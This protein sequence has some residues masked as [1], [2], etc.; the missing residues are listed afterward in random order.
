MASMPWR[1]AG[2]HATTQA[3]VVCPPS[4]W[5]R[6]R[7]ARKTAGGVARIVRVVLTCRRAVA[8]ESDAP[9][10][11]LS[12][13]KRT[14]R[15]CPGIKVSSRPRVAIGLGPPWAIHMD[16]LDR[17]L[18]GRAASLVQV[19]A[20]PQVARSRDTPRTRTTLGFGPPRYPQVGKGGDESNPTLRVRHRPQA[21][22][23]FAFE[24]S[25]ALLRGDYP[26]R[27]AGCTCPRRAA[28][29]RGDFSV[30]GVSRLARESFREEQD[31]GRRL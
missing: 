13:W 22:L 9:R 3:R 21:D 4:L 12:P 10:R 25:R 14:A 20:L 27:G 29:G 11:Y 7:D 2:G 30:V 31:F 1:Q 6:W 15:H 8:S 28:T 18:S 26:R 5:Q 19:P 17:A 23:E 16:R 24:P